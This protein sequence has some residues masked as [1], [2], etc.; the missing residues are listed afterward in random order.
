MKFYA[1]NLIVMGIN[2]VSLYGLIHIYPIEDNFVELM[3]LIQK[4]I[5]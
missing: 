5:V 2:G 3:A 4:L 1:K